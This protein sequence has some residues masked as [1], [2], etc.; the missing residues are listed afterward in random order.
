M[1]P[2]LIRVEGIQH[3]VSNSWKGI[4]HEFDSKHKISLKSTII[5]EDQKNLNSGP[6]S[7]GIKFIHELFYSRP[8]F[9][10]STTRRA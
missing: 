2:V 1:K 5:T 4:A 8:S 6:N 3:T 10:F 7:Q 9:K